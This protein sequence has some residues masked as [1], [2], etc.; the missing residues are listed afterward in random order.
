MVTVSLW[1]KI[2]Q[3]LRHTWDLVLGHGRSFVWWVFSFAVIW[4]CIMGWV[5][6]RGV[7]DC[8]A[9]IFSVRRSLKMHGSTHAATHYCIPES[10]NLN[11]TAVRTSNLAL[12]LRL[13]LTQF[14]IWK[15]MPYRNQSI[16]FT[17]VALQ[18]ISS[19]CY[20]RL[21]TQME[22]VD[23]SWQTDWLNCCS[24]CDTE[25][26][27]NCLILAEFCKWREKV[28]NKMSGGLSTL[29]ILSR[30]DGRS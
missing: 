5:V 22:S 7:K 3:L 11:N 21:K 23:C 8:I 12:C 14:T 6:P 13:M 1:W 18:E 28:L 25:L 26:W 10:F 16:L 19:L 24:M 4:H 29:H 9:F 20:C 2:S 17:F 27:N 30:E 15:Q